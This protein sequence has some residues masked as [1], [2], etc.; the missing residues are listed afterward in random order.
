VPFANLDIQFAGESMILLESSSWFG[1][2]DPDRQKDLQ[3]TQTI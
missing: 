1:A 3:Q 2:S